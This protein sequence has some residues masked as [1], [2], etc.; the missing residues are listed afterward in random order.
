[1]VF[2]RKFT[3][4]TATP[5]ATSL[6]CIF[7][8]MGRVTDELHARV[9]KLRSGSIETIDSSRWGGG[10][11]FEAEVHANALQAVLMTLYGPT[12]HSTC[13]KPEKTRFWFLN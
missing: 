6:D 10:S 9:Q 7:S 5:Q 1:M 3:R 13:V 2:Q 8:A 4:L 11:G 12:T